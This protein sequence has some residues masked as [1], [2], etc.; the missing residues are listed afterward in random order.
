MADEWSSN[1]ADKEEAPKEI[2][3]YACGPQCI[4][5]TD[6]HDWTGPVVTLENGA[7]SSCAKC[8]QLAIDVSMWS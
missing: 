1:P 2:T 3:R 5:G 6:T 7:S 4:D 8:G